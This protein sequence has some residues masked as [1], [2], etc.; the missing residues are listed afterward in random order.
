MKRREFIT[1]LGSAAAWP[2]LAQAQ[3]AGMP[4]VGFL[5][6]ARAAGSGFLIEGLRK[7]LAE[8]GFVEGR[9]LTIDFA[10][11]EDESKRLPALAAE[12]VVRHVPVI[13]SSA[14]NATIA[15]KAATSTIPVVFAIAND[16]V[17]FGL[18]ASLSRPGGNLTGVSY[19]SAELGEKRLGLIHELLP[20]V[21][22]FAILAHP[23]YPESA[24]FISAAEAAA[25]TLGLRIEVFNA[26]TES[27]IDTAFAALVA[28]R[29]GALLLAN[30]PLFSTR[31]KKIIELAARYAVPIMYTQREFADAGGLISYGPNIPDV[32]RL[33][34]G[35]AGR[36]LKG[37]KP[38]DLPV[39][40]PTKFELVINLKTATAL[41]LTIPS[42]V[43]AIADEVIE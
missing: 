31:R 21:T 2:L 28:R 23:T 40:Q 9:N 8:A 32:Y 14:L 33:A 11:T 24:P 1:L 39:I 35:Y 42:G 34:G 7:G 36:I 43:I 4:V 16:P 41:G 19:L 17:A 22:D 20:K 27:E 6:D 15:A 3:Q 5:R 38:A 10:L 30:N 37:D 26:S 25:R 13:V 29:P 12:L 18:V